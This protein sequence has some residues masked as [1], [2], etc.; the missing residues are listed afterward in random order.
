MIVILYLTYITAHIVAVI[1]LLQNTGVLQTLTS[2]ILLIGAIVLSGAAISDIADKA[3]Y[4]KKRKEKQ[5]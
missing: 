2:L 1:F 3:K 5:P 4:D